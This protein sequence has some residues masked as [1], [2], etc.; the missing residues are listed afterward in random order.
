M[1]DVTEL[2]IEQKLARSKKQ[3]MWFA[4]ASLVM[5]F[6]GLTSAYVVSSSRRDW[7]DIDMPSEFFYSTG[8][9]LLSSLTLW[10]AK[11]LIK[12]DNKSAAMIFTIVTFVLGTT[13]VVMQFMGF[14]SI[15]EMGYRFTGAASNVNASFIYVIVVAHLAHIVAGLICLLVMTIQTIRGKYTSESLLGFEL[16]SMFWHFV[17]V[18]WIYLLLFLVFAK[19][20]F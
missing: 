3:M 9:I 10:L 5:M 19:D 15:I 17:D 13:F 7:V 6:A 2:P 4:I 18:L 8:V 1:T 14:N 11:N 16:G 20:I 12:K